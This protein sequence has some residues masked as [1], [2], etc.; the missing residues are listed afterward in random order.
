MIHSIVK[1]LILQCIVAIEFCFIMEI[2]CACGDATFDSFRTMAEMY[3][4]YHANGFT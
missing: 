4:F 3:F 1:M 2:A